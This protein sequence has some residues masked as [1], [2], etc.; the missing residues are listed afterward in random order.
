MSN[1]LHV[2]PPAL[3]GEDAH[4]QRVQPRHGRLAGI[5]PVHAA[6]RIRRRETH[7][8]IAGQL[9][10]TFDNAG[11]GEGAVP[12]RERGRALSGLVRERW[13]GAPGQEEPSSCACA[14]LCLRLPA[15]TTQIR[16]SPRL[17]SPGSLGPPNPDSNWSEP[18]LRP[19]PL[20]LP[21]TAALPPPSAGAGPAHNRVRF[22]LAA[23]VF[24]FELA[25]SL[26][27]HLFAQTPGS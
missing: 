13:A 25:G 3:V 20:L 6:R 14:V 10:F 8:T 27:C 18:G 4:S 21:S 26:A 23:G 15:P 17:S 9:L 19:Q 12:E 2:L 11:R 1:V 5:P 22:Q 24:A 16:R 7:S